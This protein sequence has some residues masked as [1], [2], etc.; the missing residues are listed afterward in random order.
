MVHTGAA[1]AKLTVRKLQQGVHGRVG[2]GISQSSIDSMCIEIGA[3]E[4]GELTF[5]L[6]V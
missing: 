5:R 3:V 1:D 6:G 4:L 2:R